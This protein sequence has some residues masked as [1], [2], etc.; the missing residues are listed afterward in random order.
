[1]KKLIAMLLAM[2][3]VL[4]L[5]ACGAK[6]EAPAPTEAPKAEAPAATEAPAAP[7]A[8]AVEP[9]TLNVAYMPN[10]GALWAV[11]AAIEQGYFAEEGITVN[12]VEFADGPTEIA[13]MESGSIDL[14]YIGHGAHKLCSTG[15]AKIF[16]LQQLDD[17][18]A[19]IGFKSHGVEKLEDLKGKKVAYAPGTSSEEILNLA[20]ESVGLTLADIE[21][22]SME[23]ANMVTAAISGSVDAIAA[24][25]PFTLT[26]LE[27]VGEDA[28]KFCSNADFTDKAVA[29]ASWVCNP[30]YAE[31]NPDI[32]VRFTRA[33]FKGMDFGSD[34]ANYETIAQY[35]AAQCKTDFEIAYQQRGDAKW[36]NQAEVLESIDN[37]AM[38]GYYQLQQDAFVASGAI[39]AGEIL[40]VDE[41]VMYD[42][43]TAAATAPAAPAAPET[44]EP[45]TLNVAYMPNWGSLW[46][47]ATADAMGF[48]AEEN[49][50]VQMTAFEDGPTEIAAMES[51][52][53]DV[54]FIGPGAHKLSAKGQADVFLLQ[55]LGDGDCII[56]LNGIKTL[57]ELK[58]KKIG[59]AAGTSSESILITALESV[60]MTLEDVDALSMD[61]TAL[62][63]AALS[64]SVDAVAAW[65]PYSLT[66][67]AN[68][69]DATDI[70]SNVDFASMASPG[71]WVANPKWAAENED[72]L[73]RFV[74][75][76]YKAMDYASAATTDDAVANEVAGF[77]AKVIASDAETVIGQRYDGS[78]LSSAEMMEMLESGKLVQIYEDQKANFIAGGSLEEAG[79]LPASDFVLTAVMEAAN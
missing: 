67:L 19:V 2:V 46:A 53:M 56:G 44:Q 70:C 59:Y 68:A 30:K 62:T 34:P 72:A 21:G 61:A 17:A 11:T 3:M 73:V 4:S 49:I 77:I 1:M 58:G 8:P 63:T 20:L 57:E 71:S 10:W 9:V 32:L 13:A 25:S 60:G 31:E 26:I 41:F 65:S 74:R 28:I 37:G 24:W 29:L 64:G 50:T 42:V 16:L 23:P 22:Y 79:T 43:M 78:W 55:H 52:A 18:D 6:T 36:L 38:K 54:A 40:T 12:L 35:V 45:L 75:A 69:K 33:L 51:G 5:A 76:M 66:I 48:F 27:E 14:S 15:N 47:V 7:E 39:N